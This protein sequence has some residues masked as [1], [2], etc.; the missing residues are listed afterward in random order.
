MGQV[1]EE[2]NRFQIRKSFTSALAVR[3]AISLAL[4]RSSDSRMGFA[5][6]AE[7]SLLTWASTGPGP[8]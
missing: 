8:S 4:D 2:L 5:T 7:C 3:L 1:S 6:S